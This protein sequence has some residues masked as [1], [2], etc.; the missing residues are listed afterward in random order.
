MAV[1]GD[2]SLNR[3][4]FKNTVPNYLMHQRVASPGVASSFS[5]WSQ[6]DRDYNG[7]AI[8]IAACGAE[9]VIYFSGNADGK[10]CE[11]KSV[12]Y[13]QTFG[14][15]VL[16]NGPS[17]ITGSRA[18]TAAY[19]DPVNL[20]LA[21]VSAADNVLRIAR[22]SGQATWSVYS[23]ASSPV[24]YSV[25]MYYDGDYNIIILINVNNILRLARVIFG[26]GYRVAQYTFSDV[27]YL[28][29]SAAS[30]YVYDLVSQYLASLP[31]SSDFTTARKDYLQRLR[32][33]R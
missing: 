5:S 14:S 31:P 13:G 20:C 21:Y 12:D 16:V 11:K 15:A 17:G 8:A 32:S 6:L 18:L 23:P 28:N 30:V 2:G 7:T 9:V 22:R 4:R 24:V 27:Q 19:K 26:D 33:G 10:V 29:T 3:V 1:P 25:S